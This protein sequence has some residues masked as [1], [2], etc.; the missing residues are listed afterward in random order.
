MLHDV[1]NIGIPT[2][3]LRRPGSLDPEEEALVRDHVPLGSRL[4]MDIP[5]LS[6]VVEA[7]SAH[8]ERFDGSG[9]PDRARRR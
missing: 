2:D 6:Q 5:R 4:I 9:Y 7:V 1:G 8:H 3:L